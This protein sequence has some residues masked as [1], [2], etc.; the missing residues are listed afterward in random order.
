MGRSPVKLKKELERLGNGNVSL[1]LYEGARHETHNELN[2]A[3]VYE[4]IYK[5]INNCL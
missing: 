4:D 5:W 1:K 2:Y 3:E